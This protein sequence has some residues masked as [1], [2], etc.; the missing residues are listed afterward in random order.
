[1]TKT[2]AI[3][4]LAVAVLAV[5]ATPA[6][7]Q[8]AERRALTQA[9][10]EATAADLNSVHT[11]L[12]AVLLRSLG[13]ANAGRMDARTGAG[14]V[15]TEDLGIY[16]GIDFANHKGQTQNERLKYDGNATNYRAGID[17]PLG[18]DSAAGIF[19]NKH[20]S[21][22]DFTGRYLTV[23][24]D[25]EGNE[26][27]KPF[28]PSHYGLNAE[29]V[30]GYVSMG[31]GLGRRI[32]LQAGVGSGDATYKTN[33]DYDTGPADNI[34]NRS[35]E[36]IYGTDFFFYSGGFSQDLS[37]FVGVGPSARVI[38]D[39]F[40]SGT[41]IDL[42]HAPFEFENLRSDWQYM[43]KQGS[44]EFVRTRGNAARLGVSYL[45]QQQVS[46]YDTLDT[47]ASF[48]GN[49]VWSP[50]EEGIGYE[51][52]AGLDYRHQD[53]TVMGGKVRYLEI[54]DHKEVGF[55]GNFILAYE[56]GGLGFAAKVE[57]SYGSASPSEWG[58]QD[59]SSLNLESAARLDAEFGY[60]L[61]V[62]GGV[63]QPYGGY[64]QVG[65]DRE[66]ALGFK[67]NQGDQA[68]Q[69]GYTATSGSEADSSYELTYK[70]L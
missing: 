66:Y 51:A 41:E 35:D 24:E 33:W 56:V 42:E 63:L 17:V 13:Y 69:L 52:A 29:S 38:A 46:I 19:V 10:G 31:N 54:Q 20:D 1:M 48:A 5:T 9:E 53:R 39:G 25:Y 60:G 67:L 64:Q 62:N 49:G 27:P 44:D 36:G 34:K 58:R 4:P 57:P 47:Y 16:G 65:S 55:A 43:L 61:A 7:A 18:Y 30:H 26:T 59:F 12:S 6:F 21:S 70:F 11:H 68:W 40:V 50:D 2:R 8:N 28:L 23:R 32:W 37:D 45:N 15:G 22:L 14:A 3:S